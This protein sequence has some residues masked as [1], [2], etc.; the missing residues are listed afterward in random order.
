MEPSGNYKMLEPSEHLKTGKIIKF[1]ENT[2]FIV[3]RERQELTPE[4]CKQIEDR[5]TH[6]PK[7]FI[8]YGF[9]NNSDEVILN[10][11]WGI[12]GSLETAFLF[13]MIRYLMEKNLIEKELMEYI[14]GI[15]TAGTDEARKKFLQENK[16][17]IMKAVKRIKT[18]CSPQM[19]ILLTR[20]DWLFEA[21][22]Y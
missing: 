1:I 12:T 14:H 22:A 9:S 5:L 2:E 11:R 19:L 7:K 18:S 16:H 21:Q 8:Y 20:F 15:V 17:S 6:F 10:I 13:V 3:F 4:I